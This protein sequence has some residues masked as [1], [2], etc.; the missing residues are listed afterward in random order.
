MLL[1]EHGGG[2]IAAGRTDA[3]GAPAVA[4]VRMALDLPDRV[5]GV[6][7]APGATVRRLTQVGCTVEL[8]AGEDGRG[9]VVATPPSWRPDLVEPADLVEE[10]LRL[11]GYEAIPS[12]LPT[13]PAGR[14]AHTRPAQAPQGVGGAGRG[15]LRRGTAVP[16]RRAA[17]VGRVRA[18]RRRPTPPHR[19]RAQPARRRPRPARHH[20][21]AG[22]HRH[23]RAQPLT[24]RGRS[25]AVHGRPGRA[26]APRAA[27]DARAGRRRTSVRR[28]DR[29]DRRR[30]AR[31]AAARR[32]GTGR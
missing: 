32:R 24:G 9:Q 1:V 18:R 10:V 5:A 31:P 11:E 29:A 17:H 21:A 19:D 3:G 13:A 30:A 23:A 25:R 27:P 12:R 20:T 7:Y 28:R 26:A 2:T 16:V 15:G 14:G 6:A 4:P 22:P 8:V